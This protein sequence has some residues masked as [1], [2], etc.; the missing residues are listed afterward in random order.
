MNLFKQLFK[1]LYSPKDIALYRFQGIGKTI[2]Y[3]FLLTLL[4]VIPNVYY[5][6]AAVIN[7]LE[8]A[9]TAVKD[10]F[11]EFTIESGKLGARQNA[12]I[13]INRDDFA[14]IFDST[15][16]INE[17]DFSEE[18]NAIAFLQNEIIFIAGGNIQSYPYSMFS[19][20]ITSSDLQEFL[21][22]IDSVT[23]IM[24]VIMAIFI[25]IFSAGM[26]FI[27]ISIYAVFGLLFKNMTGK[28]LQYGHLWRMSAYSVTLPTI[29]FTIMAA[30]QTS[31][32]NGFLINWFASLIVLFLAIK[33]VPKRKQN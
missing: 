27:E 22:T 3:V 12:P 4:S 8:A 5:F 28:K 24:L 15:G 21:D 9:Q 30:L 26:K 10:Q 32:L 19:F 18:E 29:F 25:Y 14:I 2:L 17:D 16:E 31:V 20:P 6:S 33:E 23:W 13:F 11:P 7:G 1:S